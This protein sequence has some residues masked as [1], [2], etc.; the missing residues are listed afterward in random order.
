MPTPWKAGVHAYMHAHPQ[1]GRRAARAAWVY[2]TA[3]ARLQPLPL[4]LL[5]RR[6]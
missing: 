2:N 3:A 5:R 1:Q 4:L 6:R